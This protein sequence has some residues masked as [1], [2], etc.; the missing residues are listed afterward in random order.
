MT[1]RTKKTLHDLTWADLEAW[2]GAKIVSRGT[3]Y[4]KNGYVRDLSVTPEGGLLA[5]VRGSDKYATT[6]SLEKRSLSSDC[7]CPY[8]GTC[9]HAVAVVLE[10]L[11]QRKKNAKVPL[12]DE[13]DEL[14]LVQS[15]EENDPLDD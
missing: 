4:Q 2:A 11:D 9:K 13:G 1:K 6:V 5:W 10:Y 8:G 14:R 15:P 3:S 12:A 7:T